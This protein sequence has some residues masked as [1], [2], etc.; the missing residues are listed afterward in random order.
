MTFYFGLEQIHT[1]DDLINREIQERNFDGATSKNWIDT[2]LDTEIANISKPEHVSS[3]STVDGINNTPFSNDIIGN[4]SNVLSRDVS[5]KKQSDNG[6]M[7][8]FPINY[9]NVL[10]P[11]DSQTCKICGEFAT[12]HVHYGARSCQSC[13]AFFR[14]A[15]NKFKR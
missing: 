4:G 6:E 2:V 1:T 14:R 5:I 13:R 10:D 7:P 12:K 15:V 9:E 8:T 3:V 11:T